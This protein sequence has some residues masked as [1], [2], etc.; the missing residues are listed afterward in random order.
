MPDAPA[1]GTSSDS[2]DADATSGY[3]EPSLTVG[4]I[5]RRM[6]TGL[7]QIHP[8]HE[9]NWSAI[10]TN[11]ALAQQNAEI[12]REPPL[13]PWQGALRP[14]AR[15][16]ARSVLFVSRFIT[17][18]QNRFNVNVIQALTA[19][20]EGTRRLERAT[21]AA[22]ERTSSRL[23]DLEGAL[24]TLQHQLARLQHH[25]QLSS[26]PASLP[27]VDDAIALDE[28]YVA[29]EDRFRGSSDEIKERLRTYLPLLQASAIRTDEDLFDVGCGRGEWLDLLREHGW[30]G[31]GIDGNRAMVERCRALELDVVHGDALAFLRAQPAARA[32]LLTAF[33]VA[34]H[35]D[36][37]ALVGLL[38]EA[39]RVLRHDGLILIETPNPDH[40]STATRDFFLDPTHRHPLPSALLIFLA[41]AKGF[42]RITVLSQHGG[43]DY[44][45]LAR[46][47]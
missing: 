37:P 42:D 38:D 4:E 3:S 43:R 19:L 47:A 46:R 22:T 9:H 27:N 1:N 16:V 25:A 15:G 32:A 8:T 2:S 14:L 40:A 13:R 34:E 7:A 20:L 39:A 36:F 6:Q 33:H 45:L 23:Q 41:E 31:R 35:L 29:L 18:A 5:V 10:E 21:G 28:L 30:H 12:D 44:A 17:H 26:T 24:D 11:L